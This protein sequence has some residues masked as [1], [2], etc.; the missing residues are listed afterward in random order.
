MASGG[1]DFGAAGSTCSSV[2]AASCSSKAG[3]DAGRVASEDNSGSAGAVW[4]RDGGAS[5]D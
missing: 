1:E 4:G 2:S 5:L 3:S